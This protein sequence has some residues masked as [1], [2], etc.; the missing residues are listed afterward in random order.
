[1]IRNILQT[2]QDFIRSIYTANKLASFILVL[3][4]VF[5]LQVLTK[6]AFRSPETPE[7]APVW[8]YVDWLEKHPGG[9]KILYAPIQIDINGS[10]RITVRW[11]GEIDHLLIG[12]SKIYLDNETIIDYDYG[13][14]PFIFEGKFLLPEG[15]PGH[16]F[17][18]P[19]DQVLS[20]VAL[21][22]LVENYAIIEVS[23]K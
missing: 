17:L 1:M 6:T 8:Y 22:G 19:G 4:V 13:G 5:G 2:V 23:L 15:E 21:D 11:L 3:L 10:R 9:C 12:K 18:E 7:R 16:E 14:T 20:C